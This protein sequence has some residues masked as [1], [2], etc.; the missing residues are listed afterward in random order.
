M[1]PVVRALI[2]TDDSGIGGKPHGGFLHW[3][4]QAVPDSI[5]PNSREFHLGEFVTCLRTTSWVGFDLEVTTAHRA[6][7][8]TNGMTEVQLKA[9]RGADV[10]AFRFDQPFTV[11]GQARTLTDY[12][13]ALFFSV[14]PSDP[15]PTSVALLA[16]AAAVAAY[17]EGGGGFFATGDHANLGGQLC[18]LIP[19]VRSMRRWWASGGP[20]GEPAA[21]EP[22]GAGRH[23]TTRSGPDNVTNFE[24]QS[25]DVPQVISPT[26]YWAG[27]EVYHG[28]PSH[29]FLPH[30]LLCSPEGMVNVLP[31]HM[32]EGQVEVPGSLATRT[33]T[34]GGN[35][36]REYPDY[37]PTNPPQGYVVG[38]LA[39]EVVATGTVL[40]GVTSP[41]L[42]P[43][44]Q[45]TTTPANGTTFG[46]VGAW[47]GH[48]VG[49][50]RVAVD[51][52][53]HHF[54]DINLSGDR[55]LEDDSLP[56][57]QLQKLLGFYVA[58][59]SGNSVPNAAYRAIRWYY[60]NI[61][62]WLIPADRGTPIWWKTLAQLTVGPQLSEELQRARVQG[63][64]RDLR[65]DH[66][67]YFGQLA[68][69]YLAQARGS[70]ATHEVHRYIHRPKIPWWEWVE[71]IVDI[72][73]P[74]R[75]IDDGGPVRREQ[76]LGAIG[77]SARPELVATVSL[78]AALVTA[79]AV[80][81]LHDTEGDKEANDARDDER[82]MMEEVEAA[83]GE[84]LVHAAG[85][86]G[87]E[88]AGAAK[89]AGKVEKLV[90]GQQRSQ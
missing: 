66:F 65:L 69:D 70:C 89:V 59:G 32:H 5:G 45:H 46:V 13:M 11:N 78:G 67:L 87:R 57:N 41:A 19:R 90:A 17:M 58:D 15:D 56:G 39:P 36:V 2:V 68:E 9:D 31:D 80:P 26:L 62:Y 75:S 63:A 28:Y 7:V 22:L 47:D 40:P 60:R 37:V 51:S 14:Y 82:R 6:T 88:L 85:L 83:Y 76:W 8:G 30:P 18:G 16:E 23:D 73:D 84:V 64:W 72:W 43:Q 52:T 29:R 61:I 86:L 71:E 3:K 33:F 12:D 49:K 55:Y 77:L 24:D 25:D 27:F 44:H 4:D 81:A 35:Q 1:R 42:D 48:R 54:F 38:P 74:V 53:W 20:N 79:A 21:P 10:V 34:L 50:G